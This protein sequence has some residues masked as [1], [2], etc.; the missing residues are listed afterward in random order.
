MNPR[1]PRISAAR[2]RLNGSAGTVLAAA[3]IAG[4]CLTAAGCSGG[5]AS[6]AGPAHGAPKPAAPVRK[7]GRLEPV[8]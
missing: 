4:V 3:C 5:G 6:S 1:I 8:M 2:P 7:T